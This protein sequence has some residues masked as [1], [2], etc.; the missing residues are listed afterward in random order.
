ML[1]SMITRSLDAEPM[2]R[3]PEGMTARQLL[4]QLTRMQLQG[5]VPGGPGR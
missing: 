5:A 4:A 1:D 3:V 2:L